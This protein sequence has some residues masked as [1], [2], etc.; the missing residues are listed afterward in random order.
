MVVS[1]LGSLLILRYVVGVLCCDRWDF[2]KP[3]IIFSK[4]VCQ[5]SSLLP[6]D[7]CSISTRFVLVLKM[8]IENKLGRHVIFKFVS[9][10]A[11][12]GPLKNTYCLK[13]L[14]P[15]VRSQSELVLWLELTV[16]ILFGKGLWLT[17]ALF[18]G[19]ISSCALICVL[20]DN[21]MNSE[22]F[23]IF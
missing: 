7:W 13:T 6:L 19:S 4:K 10:M 17:L 11:S 8:F 9:E 23:I 14:L 3:G 2:L 1:C 18:Q 22:N 15:Y 16:G 20:H 5:L 12:S 21:I